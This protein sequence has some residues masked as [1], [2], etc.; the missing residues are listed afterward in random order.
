MTSLPSISIYVQCSRRRDGY[1]AYTVQCINVINNSSS[2]MP[3]YCCAL[4]VELQKHRYIRYQ[5]S[6]YVKNFCITTIWR[7]NAMTIDMIEIMTSLYRMYIHKHDK[8]RFGS[9][10]LVENRV[11]VC[12]QSQSGTIANDRYQSVRTSTRFDPI[13]LNSEMFTPKGSFPIVPN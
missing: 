2:V 4:R 13:R 5:L 10:D 7:R 8:T 11:G 12:C 3:I 9:T 1:R 6:N